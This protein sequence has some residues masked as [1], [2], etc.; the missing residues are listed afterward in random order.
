M[1]IDMW[2]RKLFLCKSSCFITCAF[3]PLRSDGPPMSWNFYQIHYVIKDDNWCQSCLDFPDL[4]QILLYIY[5]SIKQTRAVTRTSNKTGLPLVLKYHP[6][7]HDLGR[8]TRKKNHL[9]ICWRR[10]QT[11]LYTSPICSDSIRF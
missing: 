1:T 6:R 2:G 8:I 3:I 4:S 11:G 5:K 7:F 9:L 10:S